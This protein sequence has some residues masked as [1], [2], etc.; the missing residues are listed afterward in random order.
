[1][2]TCVSV[3]CVFVWCVVC[4]CECVCMCMCVWCGVCGVACVV[5]V[6]RQENLWRRPT[7]IGNL[8][9]HTSTHTRSCM[10]AHTTFTRAPARIHAHP[11]IRVRTRG[12]HT[13]AHTRDMAMGW[14]RMNVCMCY[15]TPQCTYTCTYTCTRSRR[16]TL[17]C[18]AGGKYYLTSQL[19]RKQAPAR[20]PASRPGRAQR[21]GLP[22]G[23]PQDHSGYAAELVGTTM[24]GEVVGAL[25]VLRPS[26]RCSA[27]AR[28]PRGT[29]GWPTWSHNR[30]CPGGR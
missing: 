2:R 19:T 10:H 25:K 14:S 7:K 12:V 20:A 24:Q 21:Q 5:C 4:E 6:Q 16:C 29:L 23:L 1:M 26:V 11:Q 22:P 13:H 30:G 18:G 28:A 17:P 8:Q 27:G 9:P 3:A 15:V